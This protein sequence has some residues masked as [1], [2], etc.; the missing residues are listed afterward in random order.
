MKF[1]HDCVIYYVDDMIYAVQG[2]E[3]NKRVL[4]KPF[5]AMGYTIPKGF[6]WDGAS[7]PNLPLARMI[8][9]K[10]S[11][12]LKASCLHDFMCSEARS[13]DDRKKADEYYELMLKHVE[14]VG[15][16]RRKFSYWGVRIGAFF[17]YGSNY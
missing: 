5:K 8:A 2:V 11:Q 4:S 13:D 12:N 6:I 1:K 3:P 7:S 10:F 16:V 9:P 14:R 17:G 15:Y